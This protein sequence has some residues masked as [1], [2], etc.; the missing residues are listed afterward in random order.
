MSMARDDPADL[1]NNAIE[2]LVKDRFELPAFSALNRLVRRIRIVINRRLFLSVIS[3][4]P[5]EL[6]QKLE[7]LLEKKPEEKF[8]LF[9]ALKT[10]VLAG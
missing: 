4:C 7:A 8:S 10:F 5:D 3:K 6:K 9:N 1:I 2:A